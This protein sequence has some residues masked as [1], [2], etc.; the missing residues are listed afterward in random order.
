MNFKPSK[1][2]LIASGV[3]LGLATMTAQAADQPILPTAGAQPTAVF[4]GGATINGGASFLTEVP[5]SE[6]ADLLATIKP[7]AADVGQMG[8]LVAILEVPGI[9]FFNLL[10]GGI[11]VSVDISNPAN[12]RPYATKMLAATEKVT[13]LDDLIGTDTN[14]TG[15]T[16]R[17]YVGYYT[18]GNISTLSFSASPAAMAIAA[19][20]PAGCPTGT[21][22]TQAS[23]QGK[24]TCVLSG[25]ITQDVH[26]TSN[27]SYL[28]DGQVIIGEN[29]VAGAKTKL[30]ID[31]GT[32][33][34][35]TGG[36]NLLVVDRNGQLYANGSAAKPVIFTYEGDAAA[37]VDTRGQWGG[38][39]I[40]GSAT[41]NEAGG[42]ASGEGGSGE[43]GGTNDTDSSGS[44]TYVQVK[45]AGIIFT[46]SD[47]LNGIAFQGVGSGTNVDYVQVHNNSDD[48]VE[49]FGGTVNAK[50]LF[51]TGNEDD[52]IDWTQG[53]SGKV[54]YAAV[55]MGSSSDHCI[56]ADNNGDN[57]D[58]TPRSNPTISNLTCAGGFND[59]G[60]GI[61]LRE[62]TSATITNSVVSNFTSYCVDIDQDATFNNTGGSIA[63]L[64]GN[65]SM[66]YSRVST[67]CGF[68]ASTGDIFSV[69][70]WF[71]ALMGNGQGTDLGGPL[72]I[73]NGNAL[74][75]IAVDPAL[76]DPFFDKVDY[77]G[78]IKDST[79]DW[80][81]G[82]TFKSFVN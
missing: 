18:G 60:Q 32:T 51:L 21:A 47:E 8:G 46:E 25:R 27:N 34:F 41:I 3:A 73:T 82:W 35:N 7:A 76:T 71:A 23:F 9:G 42:V 54:Q 75:A 29:T 15:L 33:V 70:E 62:G 13:V 58:A 68:S 6:P 69:A 77:I 20:A 28:L 50:H 16:L 4:S 72:G 12:I 17:G 45:Y 19:P 24:P 67:G 11:W 52:S 10:S 31:A 74:N 37:T 53:W 40:N 80:T 5:A 78:A 43:Y 79:S 63:G 56:E 64:N 65:L 2:S 59:D 30:T 39:V 48:G 61:R 66:R 57:N 55:R 1:L 36:V 81:A 38:L 26:L 44:L 22:A 14:L 49:F